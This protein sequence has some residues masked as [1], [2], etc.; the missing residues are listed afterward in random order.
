MVVSIPNQGRSETWSSPLQGA[1]V[2]GVIGRFVDGARGATA[3]V[4]LGPVGLIIAANLKTKS[5]QHS[6]GGDSMAERWFPDR[7]AL[8]PQR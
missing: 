1:I 6:S 8:A 4:L 7:G 2:F 3:G 5:R